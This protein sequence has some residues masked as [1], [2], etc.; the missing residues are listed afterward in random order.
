MKRLFGAFV[1]SGLAG[2]GLAVFLLPTGPSVRPMAR[3]VQSEAI[4]EQPARGTSAEKPAAR[5]QTASLAQDEAGAETGR[6]VRQIAPEIIAPPFPGTADLRRVDPRRPLGELGVALPLELRR[7]TWKPVRLARPTVD[8]SSELRAGRYAVRIDGVEGIDGRR[9]CGEG[10]LRWRCGDDAMNAF[11]SLVGRGALTCRLPR[12][13][14]AT[15]VT[16]CRV[17][18]QDVGAWLVSNG[19][20]LAQPGGPYVKAEAVARKAEMGIFGPAA[21]LPEAGN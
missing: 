13:A 17:G 11:A 21:P 18:S 16:T 10:Q 14:S 2:I 20:A 1:C 8:S 3:P 6:N 5:T 12:R 15:I 7:D 4:G 19:W 9:S